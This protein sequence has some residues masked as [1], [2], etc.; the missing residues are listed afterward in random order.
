MNKKFIQV[1]CVEGR[2]VDLRQ[3]NAV[4]KYRPKIILL[5]YPARDGHPG[6]SFN[7]FPADE[8]PLREARSIQRGLRRTARKYPWVLS[9]VAL[10]E[11]I[12]A[13]WRRGNNLF[14]YKVDGP[15]D[16]VARGARGTA[17]RGVPR[18]IAWWVRIYLRERY[19][20]KNIRLVFKRHPG[21]GRAL[22]FL[23]SFHWNNVLFLLG[24]RS[25]D[26]A[27]RRYFGRFKGLT[28][29]ELE[30]R[31]RGDAVLW[32]HWKKVSQF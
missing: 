8:K 15:R 1:N 32:R 30:R 7:R 19:M 17:F 25:R 27:W 24:S 4:T 9:D 28:A 2:G 14:V 18:H 16:L 6:F 11:N 10:W 3:A 31:V 23:Q 21:S 13:E 22:V 20:L 29:A 12:V 5:E 26:A